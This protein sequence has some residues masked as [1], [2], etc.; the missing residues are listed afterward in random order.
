MAVRA[1]LGQPSRFWRLLGGRGCY[2]VTP[3]DP[4][5]VWGGHYE[6]GTLIWRSRWVSESRAECL[7]ALARPADPHR[8][9]ILRRVEALDGPARA[10]VVL[11]VRAGFGRHRMT[12]VSRTGGVWTGR[13]RAI[14][15][16][17]WSMP[18]TLWRPCVPHAFGAHEGPVGDLVHLRSRRGAGT[19]LPIAVTAGCAHMMPSGD[20]TTT[21]SAPCYH[22]NG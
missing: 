21:L 13:S 2:A 15:F 17:W 14:R 22:R 20:W 11:D 6:S 8:I 3:A 5:Y 12:D 19:P 10:D 4:W 16:R 18:E 1:T 7:E 9:V